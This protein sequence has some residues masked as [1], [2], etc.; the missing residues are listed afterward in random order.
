VDRFVIERRFGAK[1]IY[2]T[3]LYHFVLITVAQY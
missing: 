2:S 3:I 1:E